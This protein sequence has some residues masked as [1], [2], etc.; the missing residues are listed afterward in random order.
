MDRR[1]EVIELLLSNSN[2]TKGAIRGDKIDA[3]DP[4]HSEKRSKIEIS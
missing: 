3:E 4:L 2:E 1:D